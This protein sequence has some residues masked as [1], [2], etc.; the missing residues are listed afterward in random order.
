MAQSPVL[1]RIRQR[2]RRRVALIVAVLLLVAVG[3]YFY[4][5]GQSDGPR[6]PVRKP[7][8]IEV[9]V[10]GVEIPV[11]N[12]VLRTAIR[13]IY[14]P[15]NQVPAGAL[16]QYQRI[17]GRVA[18]RRIPSGTHLTEE[19]LGPIGAPPGLSGLAREGMRVVV[20]EMNRVQGS[21]SFLSAGD[22]VDVLAISTGGP[23]AAVRQSALEASPTTLQG[24]G[25]QPGDPGAPSRQRRTSQFNEIGAVATLIAEDVEVVRV[26]RTDLPPNRQYVVLQMKPQDA[27][28]ATLS[29]AA[30]QGLRFVHRPF[31]ERDRVTATPKREEFTH[32]RRDVRQ[33]E[34]I[35]GV[36]R[37]AE[38]A[39][40]D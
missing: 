14:L 24:G 15:P 20:V 5:F 26:P 40:L 27:H 2:R 21:A 37:S 29:I 33:V 3:A 12:A 35:N 13:P 8:W 30:N 17:Y 9:P 28:V 10:T 6:L 7:G 39:L 19:D 32:V 25:V 34:V 22:R 1:A 31:N 18:L 16:L 11:G 23:P 36:A 4:V 38:R